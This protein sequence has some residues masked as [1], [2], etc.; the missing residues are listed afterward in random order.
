[1]RTVGETA[2]ALR[3]RP[4]GRALILAL[5]IVAAVLVARSCG[6]TETKVSKEQAIEIARQ[7]VSFEPDQVNVRLL[8]RGFQSQE[9]WLVGL[10]QKRPDGTY[11]TATS[12]L[13][14]ANTGQVLEVRS[15]SG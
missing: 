3:D 15:S 9:V 2:R 8:K 5:V 4:L 6:K 10:G 1:V 13:V 7:Q 11:V 12:V 14:D